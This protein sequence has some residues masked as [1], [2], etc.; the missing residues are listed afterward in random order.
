[1]P[2][3]LTGRIYA[4]VDPVDLRGFDLNLLVSLRVLLT[5][6]HVTRS[7][8]KLGLTQPAMSASLARS[9]TL[10]RD[11]LLVR[12]PQGLV[13]TSRGEQILEQLNK[14][15]EVTERLVAVPGEFTPETCN[16][17]FA[18]MG[19]DFVEF[20]LLPSLMA[21]L[22]REAPNLQTLFKSPDRRNLEA[23]LATGELDL[24]VG[25]VPEAPKELIRR[26]LFH[27][28]FVC[29]ARRG[30]PLLHD[31]S[32]SLEHY[33][34]LPHV[35]VLARDATM[36][37]D[38]IDTAMAAIGLIRRVVLWQ[39]TFLAVGSVVSRTD[40]ISTVPKRIATHFV[41][42]LPIV[43]YEPPLALPAPDF[44]MYWHSRSQED[45]AHKWLRGKIS[46][47]LKP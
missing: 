47:L 46:V 13:L 45:A 31:E 32:L 15:M 22:A 29:V 25:Y 28:P 11:K 7:A 17:T 5:Q 26:A 2:R 21:T 14:I 18:I 23:M 30:H 20:I 6:R 9:R 8:E 36:Y 39:P 1:V 40:L 42:E 35:Q 43:A 41:Q 44:A 37:G 16:R 34:E 38:A 12:G 10:F 4:T 19:S 3:C 24:V 33:A 27:E